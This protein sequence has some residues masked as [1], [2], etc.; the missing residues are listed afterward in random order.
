MSETIAGK[1]QKDIHYNTAQ[2]DGNLINYIIDSKAVNDAKNISQKIIDKLNNNYGMT[3]WDKFAEK[4]IGLKY[5]DFTEDFKAL[6]EQVPEL[7]S[8]AGIYGLCDLITINKNTGHLNIFDYKTVK[9][10]NNFGEDNIDK[11]AIQLTLYAEALKRAGFK[12]DGIYVVPIE[13]SIEMEQLNGKD[14][15]I[16]V[17]NK[18]NGKYDITISG[19]KLKDNFDFI[20]INST[21]K[22]VSRISK[23]FKYKAKTTNDD[24]VKVNNLFKSAFYNLVDEQSIN[25]T[26]E[27]IKKFVEKAKTK[28]AKF[29]RVYKIE[30]LKND[31]RREKAIR[32]GYRFFVYRNKKLMG[33]GDNEIFFKSDTGDEIDEFLTK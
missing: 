1:E 14:S 29:L 2:H 16:P 3:N 32:E 27:D 7:K 19:V 28:D 4:P 20:K 9:N 30:D 24:L 10:L 22:Y 13:V 11:A 17:M 12:V 18:R 33:E 31:E 5:E 21:N 6:C 23:F 8:I 26:D 15:L 25:Y